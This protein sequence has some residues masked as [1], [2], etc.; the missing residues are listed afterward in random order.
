MKNNGCGL[1]SVQRHLKGGREGW[2]Y[3][4]FFFIFILPEKCTSD[5]IVNGVVVGS[6][7]GVGVFAGVCIF[8]LHD[9]SSMELSYEARTSIKLLTDFSGR[10]TVQVERLI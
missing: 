6:G 1:N 8:I 10:P 9:Y 4:F 3:L 5:G 7:K 2:L